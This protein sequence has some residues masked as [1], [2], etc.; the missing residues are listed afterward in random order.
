[1]LSHCPQILTIACIQGTI[2]ELTDP[3]LFGI[4]EE[5]RA[6]GGNIWWR[7]ERANYIQTSSIFGIELGRWC[8]GST[9]GSRWCIFSYKRVCPISARPVNTSFCFFH[10]CVFILLPKRYIQDHSLPFLLV[11][12]FPDSKLSPGHNLNILHSSRHGVAGGTWCTREGAEMIDEDGAR[13]WK[14]WLRR[15][16]G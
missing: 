9:S 4:W 2:T 16:I 8:C 15:K 3:Q 14:S 13:A 5:S 6:P 7:G 11:V 1:M 12:A 10:P